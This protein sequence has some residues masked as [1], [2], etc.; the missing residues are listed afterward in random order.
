MQIP[1]NLQLLRQCNLQFDRKWRARGR[2]AWRFAITNA[3]AF[4][5][6]LQLSLPWRVDATHR[7]VF[8]IV[9]ANWHIELQLQFEVRFATAC[10]RDASKFSHFS[11]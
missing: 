3:F 11:L 2:R 1:L 6:E 7:G 8:A 4:D 10:R 5:K 9:F